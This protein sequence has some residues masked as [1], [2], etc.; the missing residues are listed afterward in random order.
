MRKTAWIAAIIISVAVTMLAQ[1]SGQDAPKAKPSA[2]RGTMHPPRAHETQPIAATT[3]TQ[4]AAVP[5]EAATLPVGTTVRMKLETM[6][7]TMTSKRNDEF[8]G[9]VTEAVMLDGR[10]IIPV[11]ASVT[12]HVMRTEEPRRI[13]GTP[14]IDLRPES[15]TMPN[16]D[17]F[18]MS[19]TIIDTSDPKKNHVDEEGRIE[20]PGHDRTD[21]RDT[22][23]GVGAG[24]GIGAYFKGPKGALIGAT[25]GGGAAFVRWMTRRHSETIPAGTELFMELSRPMTMSMSGAA[26]R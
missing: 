15:V 11:G 23:I 12:G 22:A 8:A 14:V 3:E 7:S 2:A 4:A 16:G 18:A 19:A 5:T 6:L 17:H 21:W 1:D 13:Q 10:T 25:I 26:G 20:G 24:T 9:R